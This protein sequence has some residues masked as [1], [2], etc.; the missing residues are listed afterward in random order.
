MRLHS[1]AEEIRRARIEPEAPGYGSLDKRRTSDLA[2][3]PKR[4]RELIEEL[5]GPHFIRWLELVTGMSGLEAD[6]YLEGGGVHQI[7]RGGFLKLHT[8]FNWHRRLQRHRRINLLLYLNERWEADWGG[9][10]E[11]WNEAEIGKIDGQAG[12]CYAPLFN[13]MIIFA[14]TDFSY[15]GHPRPLEC[16]PDVTRNSIAL[17]YYSQ[18]RPA[19]EIRFDRS[20]RTNYRALPGERFG[21][22]HKAHQLLIRHPKIRHLFELFHG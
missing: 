21:L 14:T 22:R 4:T 20:E 6:P 17:Y 19:H 7:P 13:R 8:D 1:I 16:P 11:L 12:A 2:S 18:E 5:N 3:L 9:E 10:L 15:H